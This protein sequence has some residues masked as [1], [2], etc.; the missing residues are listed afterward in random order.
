MTGLSAET[1]EARRNLYR[2][3]CTVWFIVSQA[4]LTLELVNIF[5]LNYLISN[6]MKSS[7]PLLNYFART[8]RRR[9]SI[10]VGD[11]LECAVA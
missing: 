1:R 11:S 10:L 9:E 3:L 6:L 5:Q 7:L 8:D 2:S 4:Q